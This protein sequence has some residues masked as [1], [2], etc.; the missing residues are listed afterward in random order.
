[1]VGDGP[2][3]A[4]MAAALADAPAVFTGYVEG[5]ELAEVYATA[6]ILVFPSTTDTFG[7]VVLEAQASGVP[8]IV[9]DK[10][11]PQENLINGETGIVVASGQAEP[12]TEAMR[13]LCADEAL[14]KRM[15]LAAREYMND[16][17]FESAFNALYA[18]YT[19][20]EKPT[21]TLPQDLP[22]TGFL[23]AGS[24]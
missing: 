18:M 6:D 10:G 20:Q 16:R 4:E 9:S 19:D 2:Y 11:G 5:E 22:L 7:N 12:L 3:R 15:A 24:L 1:M 8:V 21:K 17:D 13:T 23:N 14:R